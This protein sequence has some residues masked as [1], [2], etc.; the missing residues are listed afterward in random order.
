MQP[1]T[2]LTGTPIVRAA[3]KPIILT[4]DGFLTI[5]AW[6]IAMFKDGVLYLTNGSLYAV[7]TH[8]LSTMLIQLRTLADAPTL[9][10]VHDVAE[11][12]TYTIVLENIAAIIRHEDEKYAGVHMRIAERGEVTTLAVSLADADTITRRWCALGTHPEP[13]C[14]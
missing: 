13:W 7:E 10:F 9:Q 1:T 4:I 8:A 5:D 14:C 6:D 11:R 2:T 3:R 12:C